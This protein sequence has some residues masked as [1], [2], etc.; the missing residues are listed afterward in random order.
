[1]KVFTR[2]LLVTIFVIF[3]FLFWQVWQNNKSVQPASQAELENHFNR[4]VSWLDSNYS[5]IENIKN[6]ILWWMIKQSADN[7]GNISLNNIYL[8]YKKDH[9]DTEPPNLSTP[10]F[11]KFY[12]PVMPDVS[13]FTDAG[14][15]DYQ[16]FFFYGLS[17][18]DEV[19]SD[20]I[21]Q[22]QLDPSFCSFHYLHPRCMTHQL[23]GLR[24]MQ[25]YQ[26][27][28]KD[29]VN[30]TIAELQ[31]DVISELT[32]DFRV[33]DA[34]IQ[35]AVM[36]VDTGAFDKVKP[37]WIKNILNAQ[38]DD[39][40]WDDLHPVIHLGNNKF[41]GHTSMLPKIA[42]PKADFHATAQAIWLLSLLLEEEK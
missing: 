12:R 42:A 9:L 6:P 32:W 31:K 35:R 7:S 39:G 28:Q 18:D 1:M 30:S 33:G 17:C 20:P 37:V 41:L 19:G 13:L 23:M 25:R 15:Q 3:S 38:N 40:S 4:A 27:G 21:I 10:M 14:L 36:L 16:I 34:Y 5:K 2:L 8:K 26:C 24:F 11:D 29:L 22:K